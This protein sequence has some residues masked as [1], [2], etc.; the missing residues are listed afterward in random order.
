LYVFVWLGGV[1]EVEVLDACRV[2]GFNLY[3]VGYQLWQV[4]W[5]MVI[6]FRVVGCVFG[7]WGLVFGWSHF[8]FSLPNIY[9]CWCVGFVWVVGVSKG[10][11]LCVGC[12]VW[13]WCGGCW[14]FVVSRL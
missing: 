14:C 9:F 10:V 6:L 5:V 11:E 12:L 1:S 8:L 3:R 2:F 13:G 7:W 4:A